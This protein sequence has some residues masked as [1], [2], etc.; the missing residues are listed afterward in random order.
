MATLGAGAPPSTSSISD[1][2]LETLMATM[3]QGMKDELAVMK[4]ELS[5]EREAADEKLVKKIKLEKAP[6]FRKKG[7]G[8]QFRHNEEVHLKVSEARSAMDK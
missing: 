5:V 2:Q 6:T 3:H 4:Q 7:H 8:K 1:A